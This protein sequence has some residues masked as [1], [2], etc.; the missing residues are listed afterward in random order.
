MPKIRFEPTTFWTWA[1]IQNPLGC[2]LP[3][4]RET[5]QAM[6]ML[7]SLWN[8]P[9]QGQPHLPDA[10]KS[11]SKCGLDLYADPDPLRQFLEGARPGIA[12]VQQD[13]AGIVTT[14]T[15]SPSCGRRTRWWAPF[16]MSKGEETQD[17][18]APYSSQALPMDWLTAFMQRF[19]T[20]ALPGLCPPT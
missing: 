13:D 15:D 19:S 4:Y 20:S 1:K 14:V 6:P 16:R 12:P 17:K 10:T 18:C 8:V 11:G 9:H 7:C 3:Q 2:L 5:N